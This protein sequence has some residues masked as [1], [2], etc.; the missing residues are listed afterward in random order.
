M[1]RGRRGRH[2]RQGNKENSILPTPTPGLHAPTQ[3][4][5]GRE[6]FPPHPQSKLIPQQVATFLC[7]F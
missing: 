5:R 6:G 1:T 2:G 4:S 3:V 7:V